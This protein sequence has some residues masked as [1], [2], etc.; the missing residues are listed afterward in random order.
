MHADFA[1]PQLDILFERQ[2][3]QH[4]KP[5]QF[6][7]DLD[8]KAAFRKQQVTDI[9]KRKIAKEAKW[10]LIEIRYDEVATVDLILNK[11]LEK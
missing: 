2:G 5:I 6:A 11:T 4:F 8:A 9:L 7:K 10:T 3:E 1:I